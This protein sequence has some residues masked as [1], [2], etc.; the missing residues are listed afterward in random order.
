MCQMPKVL[1]VQP[2]ECMMTCKH[3]VLRRA[4]SEGKTIDKIIKQAITECNTDKYYF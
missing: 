1:C 4:I 2:F 3:G